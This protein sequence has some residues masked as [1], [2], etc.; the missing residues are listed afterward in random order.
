M[1]WSLQER[2]APL[3]NRPGE[4][5]DHP[6]TETITGVAATL[7]ATP[8]TPEEAARLAPRLEALLAGIAALDELDLHGVEPFLI[9]W[10][11]APHA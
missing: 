1:S 2:G 3:P 5:N 7:A 10:P 9:S 8:L 4:M 11:T 6:L